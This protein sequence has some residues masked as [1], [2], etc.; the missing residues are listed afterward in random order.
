MQEEDEE[1]ARGS[2][3]AKMLELSGFP[4]GDSSHRDGVET[5]AR[6]LKAAL[7][8]L[9][10]QNT[11]LQDELTLIC[12]VK[13]ELEA[14]LERTK[15]EFQMEREE[16]EFK[17]NE[18]QLIRESVPT[19]PAMTLDPKQQEIQ[20]ECNQSAL[21]AAQGQSDAEQQELNKNLRA[22]CETL[23]RERD[24]ALSECQN[25]R[26][27]LQGLGTELSEKTN[28]FVLQ[29]Q[30][31][32]QQGANTVRELQ[33]KIE[34][35]SQQREELLV[36]VRELTEEKNTLVENMKE[37]TLKLECSTDEGQKL[38]ASVEE[39]KTL[40]CDLQ[41]S[42]DELTKQNEEVLSKLQMNENMAED[43]K[44]TVNVLTE[45]SEKL[46]T[47]LQVQKEEMQKLT[48][49]KVKEF[50]A[51]LEEKEKEVLLLRDEKEK[52]MQHLKKEIEGKVQN[53]REE[54][55]NI[56]KNHKEELE[57]RQTTIFDLEETVKGL[58]TEKTG[59]HQ[60]LEKTSSERNML[61][62]KL[63]DLEAQLVQEMSEKHHLE[64]KLNSLAKETEQ[65]RASIRAMEGN[66]SEVIGNATKEAEEL[67]LYIDELEKE[68]N[69][70]RSRLEEAEGE[71][72][73]EQV[74]KELRAHIRD[75]EQERNMLRNNLDDVVKDT[76]GLQKDLLEMK[77]ASEKISSENEKL[78]AQISHLIQEKDKA[79][80]YRETESIEKERGE[81]RDQLMEKDAL[82]SQLKSEMA[83]LKV[84]EACYVSVNSP[85]VITHILL[86]MSF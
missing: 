80:I 42:V 55:E 30:T 19:D 11:M 78:Q 41:Q 35:L 27:I 49:E 46:Q 81:F 32:K 34:Q 14:E 43:L 58:S 7:D 83:A 5:D 76:E 24:S 25:M 72:G 18:L 75:L 67:R 54:G 44:E 45:D 15:E 60:T 20:G 74:Q 40:A 65:A 1:T 22:Q 84:S 70:L 39:Q 57:M 36:K 3:I 79:E 13:G 71:G 23:I 52:E 37:L 4:Q 33:D 12:N 63:A 48:N 50:E 47:L 53:L 59:L 86:N 8:D 38:Q 29:Y 9:Q 28:N 10:A 6:R 61:A 82:I 73:V 26:D 77:S 69:V 56:E 68:M 31:M 66:Q 64:S 62:S 51:L 85:F 2:G 21:C 17:I 16:L